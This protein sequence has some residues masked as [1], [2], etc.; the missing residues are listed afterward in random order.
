MAAFVLFLDVLPSTGKGHVLARAPAL[1]NYRLGKPMEK[2]LRALLVSAAL[3]VAVPASA[4][5]IVLDFKGIGNLNPA[6]DF[7]DVEDE[8]NYYGTEL[9]PATPA[10]EDAGGAGNIAN[11][12][13]PDPAMS[14]MDANDSMFNVPEG[15]DTGLS[16]D[17]SSPA[18]SM[19]LYEGLDATDNVL[20]TLS[21][22]APVGD[23]CPGNSNGEFCKW[24]P[25]GVA[26]G[27]VAKS[28][29]SEATTNQTAFDDST[30]ASADPVG[31]SVAEPA[32]ILAVLSA[33][34]GLAAV[35]IGRRRRSGHSLKVRR[36]A[37]GVR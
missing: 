36:V 20:E 11:E 34:L 2:C 15:F 1:V 10:V 25:V 30:L 33:G 17:T 9:N 28:I 21:L 37:R 14:P 8:A 18:A 27:G 6:G 26:L 13:P 16:L 5:V 29:G 7:Y 31:S 22:V 12:G 19:N 24:M 35:M 23:N 3:L 32:A 4:S